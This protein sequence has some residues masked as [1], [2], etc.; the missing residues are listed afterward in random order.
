MHTRAVAVRFVYKMCGM[1]RIIYQL[2]VLLAVLLFHSFSTLG[3]ATSLETS[4]DEYFII[5]DLRQEWL[6]VDEEN[7][8]VPFVS[9]RQWKGPVVSVQLDPVRYSGNT[10]RCCVPKN[11]ALLINQQLVRNFGRSAC[12]FLDIDSLRNQYSGKI[13]VTI[14]Q[15]EKDFD[16]ISLEVVS[17]GKAPADNNPVLARAKSAKMDFFVLGLV[18]LLVFYAVL[19]NQYA[20]NFRVIYNIPRIFSSKVREDD[21]RIKLLNEA[22]IAFLIQHCLLIA[23]LLIIIVPP[24]VDLPFTIPYLNF[25]IQTFSKYILLWGE[26]ALI[27]FVT[28]WAKH[29]LLMLLGTLFRLRAMKYLHMFDFMRMSLVFWAGVFVVMICFFPNVHISEEIYIKSLIYGFLLFALLRVAVLYFRI[30]KNASF[31]NVYLFSYICVAEI[32]PLLA[33]LEL[34]IG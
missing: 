13:L 33:G 26:L 24:N 32:L 15:P 1:N 30:S 14:F 21:V 25:P 6:T 22:H 17:F 29:L 12:T 10:L 20:K 9:D 8:Y 19:R 4:D 31:R 5:K 28:I 2:L 27:V 3:Q 7:R 18:V 23:F 11:S 34:L 16:R